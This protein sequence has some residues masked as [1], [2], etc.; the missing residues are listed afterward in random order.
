M[1]CRSGG[2]AEIYVEPH[3]TAPLLWIA[4]MTPIAG[5]LA[6]LG[7]ASAW[8]VSVF[9]AVATTRSARS[10]AGRASSRSP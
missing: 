9:D 4:G 2:T 5:A 10:A 3:L 6:T 1:T 8:R 7:A